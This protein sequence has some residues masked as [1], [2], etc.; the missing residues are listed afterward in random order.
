MNSKLGAA[1]KGNCPLKQKSK[2]ILSLFV[3][4]GRVAHNQISSQLSAIPGIGITRCGHCRRKDL[5]TAR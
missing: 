2:E 3:T 5:D 4:D 1:K